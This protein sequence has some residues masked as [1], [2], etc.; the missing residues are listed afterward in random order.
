MDPS[1]FFQFL[2]VLA[3]NKAT[4]ADKCREAFELA[5]AS[6]QVILSPEEEK[7]ET[8]VPVT[9]VAV[10]I[11]ELP[12]HVATPAPE[13]VVA[14][15]AVAAPVPQVATPATEPEKPASDKLFKAKTRSHAEKFHV[16]IK[17]Y[18]DMRSNVSRERARV[19]LASLD[20]TLYDDLEKNIMKE[21]NK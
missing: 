10:T 21:T 2:N 3:R 19:I 1:L 15:V 20:G 17:K 4:S 9:P 16:I 7:T 8:V 12:V 11:P 6:Y 13:P 5:V 14:P 18:L